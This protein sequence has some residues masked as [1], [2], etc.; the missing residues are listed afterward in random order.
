MI[1]LSACYQHVIIMLLLCY[2]YVII[3]LSCIIMFIEQFI[4]K[5]SDIDFKIVESKSFFK[6]DKFQIKIEKYILF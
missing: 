2:H 6:H 3:M 1:M 4:F 5:I